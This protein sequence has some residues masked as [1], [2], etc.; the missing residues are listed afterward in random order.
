MKKHFFNSVFVILPL[1]LTACTTTAPVKITPQNTVQ[2]ATLVDQSTNLYR[3]DNKLFRSEQLTEQSQYLLERQGIKTLINLRFFDRNDD[4]QAFNRG[5]FTL[6]NA[7][8]LTWHITPKEVA[9][10][11][12]QIKQY[13]K[14]GAVLI[15]CYHGADRTGLIS[16]MYRVIYQNWSL[17]EAKRE[18]TEGPYGFHSI[19]KNLENFF[20][21]ENVIQIKKEL[22]ELNTHQKL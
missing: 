14:N 20:T 19:W 1:I 9:H 10:I 8:L 3:I 2:W 13:Q 18:M 17:D 4:Q 12:W 21:E 11:L 15:H 5:Q 7:P 16:A 22:S 6:I